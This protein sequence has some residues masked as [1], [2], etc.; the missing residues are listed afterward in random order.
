MKT[1]VKLLAIFLVVF[2]ATASFGQFG[3][4]AKLKLV[5]GSVKTLKTEK[6][7][8]LQYDYTGVKVGGIDEE[9]YLNDKVKKMDAKDPGSGEKFK[10]SWFSD[11][12]K[13]FEP[14]FEELLNK[15]INQHSAKASKDNKS[16]KYTI[17]LKT[18]YI[19]PGYNIGISKNLPL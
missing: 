15:D 13:R 4:T 16:A 17:L 2:I 14:K 9:D 11:R 1:P 10:D 19:E 18:D 5:T 3:S 6:E 12:E 7:Y 8:N